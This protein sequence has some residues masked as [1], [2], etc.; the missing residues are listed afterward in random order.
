MPA[1]PLYRHRVPGWK[2]SGSLRELRHERGQRLA[3]ARPER[4]LRH[5]PG[6]QAAAD[7]AGGMRHQVADRDLALGRDELDLGL[8]LALDGDL[9][10]LELGDELRD[11]VIQPDLPLLDHHHDGDAGHRLGRRGHAEERV[12][13]HRLLRVDIH[14]ALRLEVDHL[15][16]A[17][18]ERDGPR[19]PVVVDVAPDHVVDP[20]EP[21]LRDADGLGVGLGQV[22]ARGGA[23]RR[24][25]ERERDRDEGDPEQGGCRE[26]H[27][28]ANQK[29]SHGISF[30]LRIARIWAAGDSTARPQ[31]GG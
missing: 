5:P 17:R 20:M 9:H 11:R 19:D 29:P 7:E 22:V 1:R 14:H 25:H 4:S 3:L 16:L 21:L 27:R 26:G 31:S 28:T 18:D 6:A 23:L 10:P 30:A 8:R 24:R 12:L 2:S 13:R 15:P